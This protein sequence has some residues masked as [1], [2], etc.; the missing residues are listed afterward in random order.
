MRTRHLDVE[1]VVE[2]SPEIHRDL[3]G[4]FA[5]PFTREALAT[6][7]GQSVF[8]AAQLSYSTSRRGTVRGIHFTRCPPGMAKYVCCLAGDAQDFV[9]DLRKG[10]PTFGR[11]D[12]TRL[13][14]TTMRALY[15]PAGVGHGFAAVSDGTLIAYMTSGD[16]VPAHELALSLLDPELALP[17]PD[18]P[19]LVLSPRDRAAPT[20]K[21]LDEQGLL[22]DYAEARGADRAR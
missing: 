15:L 21:E 8:P 16:Y 20:L 9:V 14:G 2:F 13:S 7:A 3:R 17:L 6:H 22:P 12:T 1:G 11:W 18:R 19:D 5:S 4:T 10:S